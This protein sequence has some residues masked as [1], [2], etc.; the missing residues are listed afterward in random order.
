MKR[1]AK[2]IEDYD[3]VR[4]TRSGFDC[5]NHNQRG[6]P[7]KVAQAIIAVTHMEQEPGRLYLGVGAL[8]ALKHQINHVVEEVN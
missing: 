7:V 4:Q 6:D 5:L 8:A 1:P 3:V 2:Q